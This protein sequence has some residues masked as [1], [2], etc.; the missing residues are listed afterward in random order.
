MRDGAYRCSWSLTAPVY[1]ARR[2]IWTGCHVDEGLW[3]LES[4]CGDAGNSY[5]WL[6][7]TMWAGETGPFEA[8]DSAA[9][10]IPAGSEGVM[11]FLGASRMDMSEIGM[12]ARRLYF[13]GAIDV[14]RDWTGTSDEGS[15][16]VDS[17]CGAVES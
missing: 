4:T 6:A 14:Q 15:A 10:D 12:Q 9:S 16:G 8:M 3:S 17:V 5:R 2:R 13:P 11:A 7:D 1:D